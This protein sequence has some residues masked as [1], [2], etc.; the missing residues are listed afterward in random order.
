[1]Q[2]ELLFDLMESYADV[3]IFFDRNKEGF[4]AKGAG[5]II[6]SNAVG[7]FPKRR[8]DKYTIWF[9]RGIERWT[10]KKFK[11]AVAKVAEIL[12]QITLKKAIE[13]DIRIEGKEVKRFNR[14]L[15][16]LLV[17]PSTPT[18]KGDSKE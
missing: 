3:N 12:N 14:E 16:E 15:A 8:G 2:S 18:E 13:I 5:L 4:K 17:S 9:G 7:H 1:M 10:Y 6:T 11:D